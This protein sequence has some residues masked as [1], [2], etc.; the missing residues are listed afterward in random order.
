MALIDAFQALVDFEVGVTIRDFKTNDAKKIFL[1]I[2][3]LTAIVGAAH[4]LE[5]DGLAASDPRYAL[6]LK[7]FVTKARFLANDINAKATHMKERS[8]DVAL[9]QS[10][11]STAATVLNTVAKQ[12]SKK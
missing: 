2:K 6:K 5:A 1:A 8:P 12:L 9:M 7:Q 11:I 3:T 4:D 10:A